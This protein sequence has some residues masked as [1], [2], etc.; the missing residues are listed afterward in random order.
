MSGD[1]TRRLVVGS[2][3][4]AWG[5]RYRHSR[6]RVLRDHEEDGRYSDLRQD[7]GD[8]FQ[9]FCFYFYGSRHY[10]DLRFTACH[11]G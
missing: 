11:R 3:P 10:P 8:R 9:S 2:L 7:F 5:L 4:A 1:P 6:Q